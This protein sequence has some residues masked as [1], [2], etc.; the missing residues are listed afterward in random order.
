MFIRIS[1]D[2]SAAEES[3]AGK[4]REATRRFVEALGKEENRDVAVLDKYLDTA[5]KA[6]NAGIQ[7]S[8]SFIDSM[9]EAADKGLKA[10]TASMTGSS[11]LSGLN[12]LSGTS[13]GLTS[14]SPADIAKVYLQDSLSKTSSS[15]ATSSSGSVSRTSYGNYQL[16]MVKGAA[17][18]VKVDSAGNSSAMT[19]QDSQNTK[20]SK[21]VCDRILEMFLQLL[22]DLESERGNTGIVKAGLM[23]SWSET[24]QDNGTET[25][26]AIGKMN[27]TDSLQESQVTETA[28]EKITA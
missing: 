23:F 9:L 20:E 21:S 26:K 12:L 19:S 24:R 2:F 16:E 13:G 14:A 25:G 22:D 27:T 17:A 3:L 1:S 6:S 8:R 28:A 5:G 18:P 15:A 7:Q 4:F 11:W 10:I